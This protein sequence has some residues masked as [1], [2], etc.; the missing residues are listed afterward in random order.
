M[1]EDDKVEVEVYRC[2]YQDLMDKNELCP[3]TSKS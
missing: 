2:P 1:G 3:Y